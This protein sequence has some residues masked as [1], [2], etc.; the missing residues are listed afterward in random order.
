M[1]VRQAVKV[2]GSEG[3]PVW[4][5]DENI[6]Q[7]FG[8]D[9]SDHNHM[10][11]VCVGGEVCMCVCVWGGGTGVHMGTSAPLLAEVRGPVWCVCVWVAVGA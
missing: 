7:C 2:G 10:H 9:H 3:R 8:V 5:A 4:G 1:T 11:G 6:P